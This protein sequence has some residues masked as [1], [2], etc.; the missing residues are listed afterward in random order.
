[1]FAAIF[2][3]DKYCWYT[4][5]SVWCWWQGT[6]RLMIYTCFSVKQVW[7]IPISHV[8][9]WYLR[10]SFKIYSNKPKVSLT[11]EV[12]QPIISSSESRVRKTWQVSNK[13]G[14]PSSTTPSTST[15]LLRCYICV[16]HAFP[17][18]VVTKKVGNLP[19]CW[20]PSSCSGHFK[21]LK[22]GM[23]ASPFRVS[24]ATK[25][26]RIN[27]TGIFTYMYGS[28]FYGKGR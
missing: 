5:C 2:K 11:R 8:G 18:T 12:T 13:F 16:F 17:M 27:G 19:P 4:C 23:G 1:M 22:M 10:L 15:L 7:A 9:E 14:L 3:G 26:H 6:V 20:A 28:F 25:T 24:G 21:S